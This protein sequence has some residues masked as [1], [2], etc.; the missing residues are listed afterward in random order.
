MT[1]PSLASWRTGA[2]YAYRVACRACGATA[3]EPCIDEITRRPF[4]ND[5]AHLVRIGDTDPE[6][7]R[8]F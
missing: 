2:A 3:S 7:E 6:Q 1:D 8:L 4:D 5:A